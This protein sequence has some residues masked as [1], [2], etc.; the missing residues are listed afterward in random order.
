MAK[1]LIVNADDFGM[2]DSAN[3]AVF[4]LFETG[5]LL[6]STVMLP[7]K[8][9]E[10]AVN[11]SKEHPE[12]AIGL[13]LTLTAE[14]KNYRWKPLSNSP[15]LIDE[16]GYMWHESDMVEKHAKLNEVEAEIRAQIDKA[17]AMGWKP[18]HIDNHMGSLYGHYT[19]RLSFM[20]LT[21]RLMGEYGY[22]YRLYSKTDKR[23][24]PEGFPFFVYGPTKVI[25]SHFAKK[26]NVIVPDYL[27]FPEWNANLRDHGYEHYREEI[28][29]IWTNIPDGVTETYI[30]PAIETDELK[31]ITNAWRN[32]VWEYE[33][34]KDPYTHKYLEEH[35]V[36]LINYRDLI[37]MKSK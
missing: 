26:Y 20:K 14:W 21:M 4:E 1:Y 22:A 25:T 9:A 8:Y 6:S 30:H 32:R 2:C 19:G 16:E 36:K 33:L 24:C 31:S 11:F 18:S 10:D 5:N 13:H 7:C 23:V 37:E 34:M 3:K 15:S 35:G 27:L 17:H 12:Y 29:K 28:L